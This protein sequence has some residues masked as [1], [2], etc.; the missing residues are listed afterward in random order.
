VISSKIAKDPK[1]LPP[2][3]KPFNPNPLKEIQALLVYVSLSD[4]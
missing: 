3:P 2:N 4:S 1:D